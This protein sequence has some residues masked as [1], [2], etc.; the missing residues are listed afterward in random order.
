MPRR[1]RCTTRLCKTPARV[2][3]SS[4]SRPL[5]RAGPT[6]LSLK[7]DG[8]CSLRKSSPARSLT[9]LLQK[10]EPSAARMFF[11][12]FLYVRGRERKSPVGCGGALSYLIRKFFTGTVRALPFGALR[13]G[14][15]SL[16]RAGR[17]FVKAVP[18]AGKTDD[19]PISAGNYRMS[20][21]SSGT[22]KGSPHLSP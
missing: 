8:V 19:V 7:G 1:L 18:S 14:M 15:A 20:A 11:V 17:I 22:A 2:I 16:L 12:I 13:G 9:D 10:C 5:L 3:N 21:S 6:H 4:R